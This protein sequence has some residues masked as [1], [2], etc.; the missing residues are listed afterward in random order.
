[1]RDG[2]IAAGVNNLR[3]FGYPG[4]TAKNILVDKL[5]GSLFRKMV[6][7]TAEETTGTPAEEACRKILAELDKAG[8]D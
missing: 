4:C 1:M 3:E 8:I 5:Y 7:S 6:E 2:I